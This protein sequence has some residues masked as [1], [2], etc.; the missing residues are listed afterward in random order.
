MCV[1]QDCQFKNLFAVLVLAAA[2]AHIHGQGKN[3][4]FY[5]HFVATVPCYFLL[6]KVE[7]E[8]PGSPLSDL[9]VSMEE[10]CAQSAYR[11]IYLILSS[12]FVC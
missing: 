3:L 8:T 7:P 6:S 4:G 12:Q 1:R 5:A 11:M 9:Q 10:V 2:V